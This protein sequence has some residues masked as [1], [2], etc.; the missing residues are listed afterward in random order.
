VVPQSREQDVEQLLEARYHLREAGDVAAAVE[1]TEEMVSQL[2]EW[3]AY[4]REERL[5]IETVS[6]LA[7]RSGMASIFIHQL[8]I[9]SQGR[10]DYEQALSWYRK[11]LE[12]SEELGNRAGMASTISQMGVLLTEAG[13]PGEAVP[14]NLHSLGMRAQMGSPEHGID[15]HWLARQRNALGEERFQDLLREHAGE[16]GGATVLEMLDRTARGE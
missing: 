10:G 11:S 8:G 2:D 6:W 16:D 15:L 1:V 14:L 4:R 13:S 7:E 5:C 3:G 12:I 9:I